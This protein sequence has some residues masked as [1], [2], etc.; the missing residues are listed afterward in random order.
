MTY[1][2][3]ISQESPGA[4][5]FLV[6]QSRSMNKQFGID[7]DGKPLSRAV[8]LAEALNNTLAELIN[9]CMRDEGVSDYFDI[10]VIGYGKT[11]RAAFCWEGGLA[12]SSMVPISEVAQSARVSQET[13]ETEVRGEKVKET[14]SV[15]QWIEPVAAEST[16]MKSAFEMACATLEAWIYRRPKSFPPIVINISDGMAND[17]NSEQELL[18]AAQRLTGLQTTDGNVLL[19]NCHITG[20]GDNQ[21]TFPWSPMELP[22]EPYAKLLFE[23]SSEMPGSLQGDHLRIIRSRARYDPDNSRHGV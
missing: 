10:G 23:M 17:V 13:I 15:S 22:D 16:P 20:E 3:E 21:V 2:Q 12:G 11:N 9:R 4:V 5:L 1:S 6:D 14:V 19:I 7:R 18:A 8:V